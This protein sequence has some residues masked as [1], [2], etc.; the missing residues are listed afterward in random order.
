V[1]PATVIP[2]VTVTAATTVTTTTTAAA[3]AAAADTVDNDSDKS[4]T[5]HNQVELPHFVTYGLPVF[6]QY[7]YR[8]YIKKQTAELM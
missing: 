2:D 1:T 8:V 7:S 5:P 6:P 3:A 4:P